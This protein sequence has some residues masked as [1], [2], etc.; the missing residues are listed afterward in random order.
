MSRV[1]RAAMTET[2]NAFADM[3]A[4]IEELP[5]LAGRLDEIR[6][7]NL[8]HHGE[9]IERAA[10]QG[11]KLVG[12][13]ELFTAPYF[14]LTTFL[15]QWLGLAEPAEGGPTHHFMAALAKRLGVV[16]VAP[17]YERRGDRRYNTALVIDADGRLLGCFRKMHIPHGTNEKGSFVETFYYGRGDV[18][19]C[20]PVF[21]TAIGRL[22][23]AICYDRHFEGVMRSLAA[24]GAELVMSPAVTFGDKSRRMWE[25]EFEV[26]AARHNLFIGG[27]N[28]K[29]V[30]PPWTVE[31]F[32]AS[33]FVGPHGRCPNLSADPRLV[34]ADLDLGSLAAPDP[35]GWNLRRDARPDLY[36]G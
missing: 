7:A 25:L 4:T 16:I 26:D 32:G 27:S 6:D 14:A 12:L 21:E 19:P 2:K 28:K 24:N 34:I 36:I 31:Y 17:I 5:R 8:A 11:A 15:E 33:H 10:A 35:S 13:G 1:I 22:G 30:E 18:P 20:F 9:L 23:V 3:P 29:G